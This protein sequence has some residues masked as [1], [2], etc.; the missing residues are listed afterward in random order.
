M[1]SSQ[2]TISQALGASGPGYVITLGPKSYTLLPFTQKDKAAIEAW[3]RQRAWSE[4]RA[5]KDFLTSE[6][7]RQL[8]E[9]M[10]AALAGREYALYGPR[11]QTM[12]STVAG[13]IEVIR[14]MLAKRHPSEATEEL[15]EQLLSEQGEQVN[16]ALRTLHPD[17]FD[18]D[19]EGA[20]PNA[21]P[22]AGA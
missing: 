2:G 13:M 20:D 14:L 11:V 10:A 17:W 22:G 16:E 3:V 18:R 6:E 8:R 21:K 15:A 7:Y 19:K 9:D 1:M 5:A 4:V 12:L